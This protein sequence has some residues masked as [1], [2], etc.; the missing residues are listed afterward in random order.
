[1]IYFLHLLTMFF[2]IRGL[3]RRAG[4]IALDPGLILVFVTAFSV[5]ANIIFFEFLAEEF[6]NN[7]W[8]LWESR[9]SMQ[10]IVLLNL[11]FTVTFTS[12][13]I[14]VCKFQSYEKDQISNL[15]YR[16]QY[17][18]VYWVSVYVIVFALGRILLALG[19][20]II[21]HGKYKKTCL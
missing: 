12:I 2:C 8:V 14:F 4:N 11:L 9:E 21:S 19:Q 16:A 5:T 10:S 20:T 18:P 1:M 6:N 13:Y 7:V 15:T 3:Y 17:N